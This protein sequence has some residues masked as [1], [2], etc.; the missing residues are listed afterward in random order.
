[1]IDEPVCAIACVV[2]LCGG[3]AQGQGY[4]EEEADEEEEHEQLILQQ[5]RVFE[6]D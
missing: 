2:P 6:G 3:G 4:E 5:L 1:M